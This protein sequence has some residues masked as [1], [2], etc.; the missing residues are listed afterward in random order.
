MPS[1]LAC[2][3]ITWLAVFQET[4]HVPSA[5]HLLLTWAV[6]NKEGVSDAKG[7][8]PLDVLS[9]MLATAVRAYVLPTATDGVYCCPRHTSFD[10]VLR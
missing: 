7:P 9:P 1:P 6:D 3:L 2:I 4:L 5:L 8:P 10:V